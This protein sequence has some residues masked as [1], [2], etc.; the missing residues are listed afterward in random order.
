MKTATSDRG[1]IL[2]FAGRHGLSPALRAGVPALLAEK[3]DGVDRC[4]W[5]RFFAA[6]DRSGPAL[7][8][9]DG[10]PAACLPAAASDPHGW[11]A[12]AALAHARRFVD[13][14]RHRAPPA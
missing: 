4:G 5:E 2:H 11:S 7:L 3:Q 10:D 1:E 9:D 13:A 6:L 14:L 12:A 8:I